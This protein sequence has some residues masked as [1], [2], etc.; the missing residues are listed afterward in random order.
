[1]SNSLTLIKDMSSLRF[2]SQNNNSKRTKNSQYSIDPGFTEKL[3]PLQKPFSSPSIS[4]YV[5]KLQITLWYYEY[6]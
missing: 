2:M 5:E 3:R 4:S 6:H 1:M